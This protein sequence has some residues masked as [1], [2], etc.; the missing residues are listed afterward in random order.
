MRWATILLLLTVFWT[1]FTTAEQAQPLINDPALAK[2]AKALEMQLRC[3][4]CQGQSVAESDSGFSNDIRQIILEQ[5]RAG[6]T[7]QQIIDYLVARYG[8][9]IRFSPPFKM[10]TA[11]LWFGPLVL[12]SVGGVILVTALRKRKLQEEADV[13]LTDEE[14]ARL[15]A[16][17]KDKGGNENI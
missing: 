15:A 3:L 13:P 4:V 16:L 7:D 11:F 17:L 5:M 8:D 6:K 1:G 12:V 2:R 14:Q 10:T 9:F